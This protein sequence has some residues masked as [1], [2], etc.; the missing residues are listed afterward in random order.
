MLKQLVLGQK[1]SRNVWDPYWDSHKSLAWQSG[2]T[3]ASTQRQAHSGLG[4]GKQSFF[5]HHEL[6]QGASP[7]VWKDRHIVGVLTSSMDYL[8]AARGPEA[9]YLPCTTPLDH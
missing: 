1:H 8:F 7:S 6:G 5:F 2:L 3:Q 4:V 9:G